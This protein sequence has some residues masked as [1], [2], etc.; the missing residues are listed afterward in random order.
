MPDSKG[1]ILH[2]SEGPYLHTD[3]LG[4]SNGSGALVSRQTYYP[5][6]APRARCRT[7]D[8]RHRLHVCGARE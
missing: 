4:S 7:D 3:H 6:G 8:E 5:F 1:D 2:C